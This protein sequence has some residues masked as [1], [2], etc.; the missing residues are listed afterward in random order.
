MPPHRPVFQFLGI[1]NCVNTRADHDVLSP[2]R[3]A[4]QPASWCAHERCLELRQQCSGIPFH[5]RS[6]RSIYTGTIILPHPI[7][8]LEWSMNRLKATTTIGDVALQIG[9]NPVHRANHFVRVPNNTS[10][11]P[12]VQDRDARFA[13]SL[14][15]LYRDTIANSH[16][17]GPPRLLSFHPTQHPDS[18]SDKSLV[19]I[20]RRPRM[21][22]RPSILASVL[23]PPS[24]DWL[25]S[26]SAN[27]QYVLR[28][29]RHAA[30]HRPPLL[31]GS[32]RSQV[33]SR[34]INDSL[35]H[36]GAARRRNSAA[37]R[38]CDPAWARW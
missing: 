9:S 22:R 5:L 33:P 6:P 10:D 31:D 25:T 17:G 8:V 36:D 35:A 38:R 4:T 16:F 1:P 2:V 21:L 24:V 19:F 29:A 23:T 12:Q 15:S 37:A 18:F 32:K 13:F 3:I 26:N 14:H 34:R 11:D 27:E 30:Y 7:I 20:R 28:L